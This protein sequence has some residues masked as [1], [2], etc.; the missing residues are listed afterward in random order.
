[1]ASRAFNAL[2]TTGGVLAMIIGALPVAKLA[3][4]T[5]SAYSCSS[6]DGDAM[7][8]Y[9]YYAFNSSSDYK[10]TLAAVAFVFILIGTLIAFFCF[11]GDRDA[12][13]GWKVGLGIAL[14]FF[15]VGSII[16][17]SA[18]YSFIQMATKVHSGYYSATATTIGLW[19]SGVWVPILADGAGGLCFVSMITA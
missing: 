8:N 1:M 4:S 17:Y 16:G 19:G 3:E 15:A 10:V 13:T 7:E 11:F 12:G 18:I 5:C 6:G 2:A 14:G 9:Y